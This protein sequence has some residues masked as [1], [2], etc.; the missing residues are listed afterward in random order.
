MGEG[1]EM[2]AVA[3]IEDNKL[4]VGASANSALQPTEIRKAHKE[5]LAQIVEEKGIEP[6]EASNEAW[7]ILFSKLL[8]QD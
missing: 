8:K 3:V 5:L 1:I 6:Y 7:P 4:S 2:L